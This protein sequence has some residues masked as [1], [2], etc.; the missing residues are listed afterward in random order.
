MTSLLLAAACGSQRID[1]MDFCPEYAR[2]ECAAVKGACGVADEAGCVLQRDIDCQQRSRKLLVGAKGYSA[3]GAR[4]CL[5]R[6]GAVYRQAFIPAADWRDVDE[7]CEHI[8]FG[9]RGRGEACQTSKEC[10]EW[11][12]CRDGV[13]LGW[14]DLRPG[15]VPCG[16]MPVICSADQF[17]GYVEGSGYACRPLSGPGEACSEAGQCRDGARCQMGSCE[18]RTALGGECLEHRECVL[19]SQFCDPASY[20]CNTGFAVTPQSQFCQPYLR[21]FPGDGG[22]GPRPDASSVLD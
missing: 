21:G 12:T 18:A 1:E 7:T 4:S 20:T 9:H 22:P 17:C 6:M 2:V 19:P 8:Y 10:M 11:S 16:Q 5:N 3:M 14:T 13:C 15:E